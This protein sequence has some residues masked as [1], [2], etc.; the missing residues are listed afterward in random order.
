MKYD[1]TRPRRKLSVSIAGELLDW[2]QEHGQTLERPKSLTGTINLL[3]EQYRH[4]V[5]LEGSTTN[6]S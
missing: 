3:L 4:K 5:L 2:L 6:T 1:P